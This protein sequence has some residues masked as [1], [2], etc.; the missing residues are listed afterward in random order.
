MIDPPR[1]DEQPLPI[2]NAWFGFGELD[3]V[4]AVEVIRIS[5]SNED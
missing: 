1:M 3:V 2:R 4:E 5:V